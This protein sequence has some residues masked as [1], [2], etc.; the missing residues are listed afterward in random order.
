MIE[1]LRVRRYQLEELRCDCGV[2]LRWMVGH[3]SVW[4]GTSGSLR[5]PHE[6]GVVFD[7]ELLLAAEGLQFMKSEIEKRA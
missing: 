5:L 6:F 7:E 4:L 2:R 1:V 3:R